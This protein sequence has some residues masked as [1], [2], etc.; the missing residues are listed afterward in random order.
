MAAVVRTFC[1]VKLKHS[2]ELSQKGNYYLGAKL[3]R[4]AY[5][6]KERIRAIDKGYTSPIQN[7]KE[8]TDTDYDSALSFCVAHIDRIA[9][10]A[11]TTDTLRASGADS[12]SWS[13]GGITFTSTTAKLA[14]SK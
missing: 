9:I 1:S 5:M 4:G 11:G 10:C 7:T 13:K 8:D 3:V 2:F 14:I 6:E 12:Y